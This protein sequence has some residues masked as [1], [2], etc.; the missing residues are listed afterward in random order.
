MFIDGKL[1]REHAHDLSNIKYDHIMKPA[2]QIVSLAIRVAFTPVALRVF[3]NPATDI[4]SPQSRVLLERPT[5]PQLLQKLAAFY[6]SKA[7][8][9]TLTTTRKLSLFCASSI[10]PTPT[11]YFLNIHFNN[12][13]SSTPRSSKS[14][15]SLRFPHQNPVRTSPLPHTCHMPH[16]SHL[17]RF[18]PPN[19]IW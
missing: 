3:L 15:V 6:E 9:A 11:Y 7:Y 16:P 12:I 1:H 4:I 8:I 14:S 18:D 17:S 5:V 2:D 10:Q 13:N 19:G